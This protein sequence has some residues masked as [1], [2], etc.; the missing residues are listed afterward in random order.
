MDIAVRAFEKIG[1]TECLH[2][3]SLNCSSHVQP[4]FRSLFNKARDALHLL[5]S[6]PEDLLHNIRRFPL[7]YPT[8]QQLFHAR[9][10]GLSLCKLY[11]SHLLLPQEKEVQHAGFTRD[12]LLKGRRGLAEKHQ[13]KLIWNYL[14]VEVAQ[15]AAV[16]LDYALEKFGSS[17]A[18]FVM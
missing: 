16:R 9:V 12:T 15:C 3:C 10:V 4:S 14:P 1:F 5:F 2:I 6:D 8:Q 13:S 7:D 17:Q 11:V 18:V